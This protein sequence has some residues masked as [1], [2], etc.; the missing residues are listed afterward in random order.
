M[1]KCH[2]GSI[3]LLQPSGEGCI[4]TTPRGSGGIS[5]LYDGEFLDNF[6]LLEPDVHF[7][8]RP[9]EFMI[10]GIPE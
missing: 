10:I 1:S 4:S 9:G 5:C 8:A 6:W 3:S 7:Q 2:K